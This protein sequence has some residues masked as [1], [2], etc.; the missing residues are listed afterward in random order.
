MDEVEDRPFIP[1]NVKGKTQPIDVYE[2]YG[3]K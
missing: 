3:L 2:V 1:L